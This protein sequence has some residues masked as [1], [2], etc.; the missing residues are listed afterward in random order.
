MSFLV[1]NYH[2]NMVILI[3]FLLDI[4]TLG[5]T[6]GEMKHFMSCLVEINA[7]HEFR[8]FLGNLLFSK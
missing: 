6:R 3:K 7:Y 5:M 2:K 4:S 8:N 1:L